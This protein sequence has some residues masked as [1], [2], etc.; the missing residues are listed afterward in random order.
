MRLDEFVQNPEQIN[1]LFF[2]LGNIGKREQSAKLVRQEIARM[3]DAWQAWIGSIGKEEIRSLTMAHIQNFF[4]EFGYGKT[5]REILPDPEPAASAPDSTSATSSPPSKSV[6]DEEAIEAV[7]KAATDL[8][9]RLRTSTISPDQYAEFRASLLNQ[10]LTPEQIKAGVKQAKLKT[11]SESLDDPPAE[12]FYQQLIR[13]SEAFDRTKALGRAV[14]AGFAKPKDAQVQKVYKEMDKIIK[15]VV[16]RVASEKP[17][18]FQKRAASRS[19]SARSSVSGSGPFSRAA[20]LMMGDPE[21]RSSTPSAPGSAPVARQLD[22]HPRYIPDLR[23]ALEAAAENEPTTH[24]QREALAAL[25][26]RYFPSE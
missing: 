14:S 13:L 22:L 2:G 3:R 9:T 17:S 8:R 26:K 11:V 18:A 19:S 7:A 4:D 15:A 16:S 25:L 12:G 10:G 24:S 1:E 23:S 21:D 5:A 6:S 20:G